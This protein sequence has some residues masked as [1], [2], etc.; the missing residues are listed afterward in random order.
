MKNLISCVIFTMALCVL[1]TPSARAISVSAMFSDHMVLQREMPVPVW[2]TAEANETVTV[3]FRDQ[4]K[5]V[6]SDK[7][8]KWLLK[9]D[10][11]KVGEPGKMTVTGSS[12]EQVVFDDVVVGEVWFGSGQSNMVGDAGRYSSHEPALKAMLDGCPYP[13]LRLYRGGWSLPKDTN[14]VKSEGENTLI[15]HGAWNQA[16]ADNSPRMSAILF[17]FGLSLQKELGVPVGLVVGAAGGTASSEWLTEEMIAD[18]KDCVALLKRDENYLLDKVK[19]KADFEAKLAE[20]ETIA[21]AERAKGGREP[22]KPRQPLDPGNRYEKRVFGVV[23]YAIRGVLWDQGEAGTGISSID[24]YT[25]MGALIRGW[26]KAWGYDFPWIYV[27]KPSGGGCAWDKTNPFSIKA[28][29]FAPQPL[30]NN[31]AEAGLNRETHIRIMQ[32]PKTAMVSSSD[33]GGGV[34]P[35]NRSGYGTRA[36]RVALALAYGK[37]VE[38]YG[39]IYES[40]TVEGNALCVRFSHAES[41]LAV[42]E[43]QKLQGFEIAG[44]DGKYRWAEAKIVGK[45]VVLTSEHIPVPV[46]V[47]Y[48]WAESIPWANLFNGERLPALTFRSEKHQTYQKE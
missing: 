5:Q 29:A 26:R 20:W 8:G 19:R 41:G 9:L 4:K 6:V 48:A 7:N 2:G 14:A 25:M 22:S 30:E 35:G 13:E 11:L 12:G 36:C 40:H 28:E 10:P 27:Q 39:P 15:Y 3:E 18:D 47:R 38:I 23:P 17:V 33:L 43:G 42:P 16:A 46:S 31:T 21:A 44:A 34:H 24:Q 1:T 32:H 45:T 37:D